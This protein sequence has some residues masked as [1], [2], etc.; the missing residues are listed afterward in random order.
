MPASLSLLSDSLSRLGLS[1]DRLFFAMNY[2]FAPPAAKGIKKR[3]KQNDGAIDIDIACVLYDANCVIKDIVWFKQLRDTTQ[4]IRHQGDSLNGKD[5]GKETLYHAPL[6]QEQ[7]RLSLNHLPT[8][9]SHLAMIAHS[10][11]GQ[12]FSTIEAGEVHLSDD[13]GNK[14]FQIDLK[15]LPADCHALWVASLRREVDDWHLTLQNL[16]LSAKDIPKAAQQVAHELARSMPTAQT[17]AL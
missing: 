6:D 16:P 15:Q 4:S 8:D 14:A 5:R 13:E 7:I 12:A 1:P 11:Y 9:I 17:P 10:Y 3:L 2:Q